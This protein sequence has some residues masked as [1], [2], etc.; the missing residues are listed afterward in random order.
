MELKEYI[1]ERFG[2]D[3]GFIANHDFKVVSL[4][5]EE[6]VLSYKIKDSG[7]NPQNTVHGG[8]LFGLADTCAGM[9]ACMTGRFPVTTTASMN[10]LRPGV[11]GTISAVAKALKVGK[12]IGYYSVEIFDEENNL[13]ATSQVN[14]F[15]KEDKK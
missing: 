6:A 11:E 9:L 10:Y 14:M 1:K 4:T 3:N 2:N 8:L 15:F 5:D 12:T 7:L 13:I